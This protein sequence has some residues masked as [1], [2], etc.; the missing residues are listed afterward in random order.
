M[1]AHRLSS[2][3]KLSWHIQRTKQRTRSKS[4]QQ[5]WA[6]LQTEDVTVFYLTQ[7]L[8]HHKPLAQKTLNQ[9]SLFNIQ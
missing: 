3:M 2:L 8:N 4:L 6:I 9:F 7:K 5:A 1:A